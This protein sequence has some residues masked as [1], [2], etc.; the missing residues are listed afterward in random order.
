M[1][2]KPLLNLDPLGPQELELITGG[3][4]GGSKPSTGFRFFGGPIDI[5]TSCGDLHAPGDPKHAQAMQQLAN[6]REMQ[7]LRELANRHEFLRN[8][9]HAGLPQMRPGNPR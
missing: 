2:T 9:P 3:G 1:D 7:R 8:S 4:G 6:Q 5:M